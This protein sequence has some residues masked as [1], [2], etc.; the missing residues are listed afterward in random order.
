MADPITI[1]PIEDFPHNQIIKGSKINVQ[2]LEDDLRTMIADFIRRYNGYKIKGTADSL[3][4]LMATSNI[5]T[6][7]IVDYYVDEDKQKVDITPAA[8]L[9]P[10]E[11]KEVIKEVKEAIVEEKEELKIESEKLKNPAPAAAPAGT[12]PNP[13]AAG[14]EPPAPAPAEEFKNKNEKILH[15]LFTAGKVS[16]ISKAELAKAGFDTSL[17]SIR[18]CKVGRYQLQKEFSEPFYKLTKV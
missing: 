10:V 1:P 17:A 8:D 12:P 11:V 2:E 5:I 7:N 9:T 3:K 6:Q 16:D 18:G 4:V 15:D 13:P 14:T